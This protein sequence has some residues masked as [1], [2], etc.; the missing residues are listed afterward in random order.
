MFVMQMTCH[1]VVEIL[2]NDLCYS[3]V[4]FWHI[5]EAA[6]VEKAVCTVKS[7]FARVFPLGPKDK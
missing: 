6:T 1:K 2:T 5:E 4:F 7:I 3:T